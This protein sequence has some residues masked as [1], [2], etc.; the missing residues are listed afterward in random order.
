VLQVTL[1][2]ERAKKMA[3]NSVPNA[4]LSDH[5]LQQSQSQTQPM[6]IWHDTTESSDQKNNTTVPE[7]SQPDTTPQVPQPSLST[8]NQQEDQENT[9]PTESDVVMHDHENSVG[10]SGGGGG[11]GGIV[12]EKMTIANARNESDE[13][14]H[15]GSNNIEPTDYVHWDRSNLDESERK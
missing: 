6:S 3:E 1:T 9:V 7:A 12:D 14:Q 5:Q 4:V 2:L 13:K 15:H 10:D 11:G 8:A